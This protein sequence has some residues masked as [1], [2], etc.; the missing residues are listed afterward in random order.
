MH[1][2]SK[3]IMFLAQTPEDKEIIYKELTEVIAHAKE[4]SS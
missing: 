1:T 2:P 3:T 4:A